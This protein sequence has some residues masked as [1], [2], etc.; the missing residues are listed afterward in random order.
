LLQGRLVI[1]DVTETDHF[2]QILNVKR[3]I[4]SANL[5]IAY[6]ING[7]LSRLL[8]SQLENY[9]IMGHE[10]FSLVIAKA[11]DG[12]EGYFNNGY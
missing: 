1:A 4:A 7:K 3:S 9:N 5:A 12:Y 6:S 8:L 10:Y 11:L 2:I